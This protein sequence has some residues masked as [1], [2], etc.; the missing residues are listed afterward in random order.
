MRQNW[1]LTITLTDADLL[2]IGAFGTTSGYPNENAIFSICVNGFQ[3]TTVKMAAIVSQALYF[4][5][6]SRLIV[7]YR[8][9]LAHVNGEVPIGG[10]GVVQQ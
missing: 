1:Q 2:P 5:I 4:D 7:V 3:N 9:L 10:G 6:Q 8:G